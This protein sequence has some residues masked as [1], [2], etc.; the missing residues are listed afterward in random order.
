MDG[1]H[2]YAMGTGAYAKGCQEQHNPM[3]YVSILQMRTLRLQEGNKPGSMH[4]SS[5][6]ENRGMNLDLTLLLRSPGKP[7]GILLPV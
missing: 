7:M 3:T 1:D 6:K 5:E 4:T 2:Y